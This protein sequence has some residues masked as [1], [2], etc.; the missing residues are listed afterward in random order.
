LG[1]NSALEIGLDVP[2][3]QHVRAPRGLGELRLEVGE[4]PEARVVGVGHVEVGLVV[5]APEERLAALDAFDVADV[6]AARAKELHVLLAEV[7]AHRPDY[8]NV[9]E[10]ARREREVDRRAA[11]HPLS[12]PERGADGVERDR[13]DDGERHEGP[14]PMDA[15]A[16]T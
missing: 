7:V 2:E 4:Y 13:A 10:E 11:K 12:L 6:D 1:P 3:E 16:A 14:H 5:A 9:G 8:V 15:P